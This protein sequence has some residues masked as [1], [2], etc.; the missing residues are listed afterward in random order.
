M[1]NLQ[2]AVNRIIDWHYL[3]TTQSC[4][5]EIKGKISKFLAIIF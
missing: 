3:F 1:I 4:S 5:V 2:Y